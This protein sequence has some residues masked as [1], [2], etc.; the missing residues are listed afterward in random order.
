MGILD[1]SDRAVIIPG[2]LGA[3]QQSIEG[4]QLSAGDVLSGLVGAVLIALDELLCGRGGGA[5]PSVR[6]LRNRRTRGAA[7]AQ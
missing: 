1:G 6:F 7:W 4:N 3:V 5:C 2:Q